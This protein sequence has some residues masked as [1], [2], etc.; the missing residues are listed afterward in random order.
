MMDDKAAV[1]IAGVLVALARL[2]IPAD[3]QELLVHGNPTSG[4]APNALS[5]AL[6]SAGFQYVGS[7]SVVIE[8]DALA[9]YQAMVELHSN[10]G[11]ITLDEVKARLGNVVAFPTPHSEKE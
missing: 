11:G 8:R 7:E 2:N 1:E 10:G 4:I 5:A 9:A 6:R 3:I